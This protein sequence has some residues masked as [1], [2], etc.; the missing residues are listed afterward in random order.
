MTDIVEFI[1][2]RLDG[3]ERIALMATPAPW[4]DRSPG[5]VFIEQA[6]GENAHLIAQFP[7]CEEHADNREWDARH[8][9]HHDP[10]RVLREVEAHRRLLAEVASWRHLN[11]DDSGIHSCATIVYAEELRGSC[12]CGLEAR[13]AAILHPLA[14]PFADH[15]DY[16]EA[17]RP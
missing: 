8:V 15:P 10:A 5:N 4:T 11:V 13:R 17:W 9:A 7:T 6:A 1:K 2:A 12:D 14:L 16:Q 3:D